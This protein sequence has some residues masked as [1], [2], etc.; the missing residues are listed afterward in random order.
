MEEK[1]WIREMDTYFK[2]VVKHAGMLLIVLK[3][4]MGSNLCHICARFCK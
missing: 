2:E 4:A 3:L 1:I